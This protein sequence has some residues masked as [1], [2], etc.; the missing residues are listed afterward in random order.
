MGLSVDE[1]AAAEMAA[2]IHDVGKISVPA[3]IL[4]KPGSLSAN[5]FALIRQHPTTG[6]EILKDIAYPWPVAEAVWQH[7]ERLD[8]SGYPRGL[9]GVEICGTARVVAVAD[10]VEAMASHRPYRPA[11]GVDTAVAEIV[12]HR[13]L[14]DADVMA[15]CIRL[16]ESGRIAW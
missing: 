5:E 10:V 13:D 4:N 11:Q 3:E 12:A 15:A 16:H 1:I 14:Y 9:S 7:H 6:Y 8:G 2:V